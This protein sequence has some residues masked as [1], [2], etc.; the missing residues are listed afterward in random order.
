MFLRT[1]EYI[2]RPRHDE[3]PSD[4]DEL[5]PHGQEG[6]ELAAPGLDVSAILRL[7]SALGINDALIRETLPPFF[8]LQ[9][10]FCLF[11]YQK[12]FL[13]DY[14]DK[15][16]LAYMNAASVASTVFE[17]FLSPVTVFG[18]LN[19][20]DILVSYVGFVRGMKAQAYQDRSWRT[21]L[22]RNFMECT[23]HWV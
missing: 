22:L 16:P 9:H 7:A 13:S 1:Y 23:L 18:T 3:S 2:C 20:T 17:Y 14:Y 10:T 4:R 21:E 11:A 8:L 19:W 5:G 15:A 6:R 12:P